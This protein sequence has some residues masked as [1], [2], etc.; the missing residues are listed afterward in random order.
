M[1]NEKQQNNIKILGV[2]MGD[3]ASIGPEITLQAIDKIDST[4]YV[5]LIIGRYDVLKKHY[6]KLLK[7]K[8][9]IFYNDFP[10]LEPKKN[11]LY[12]YDVKSDKKIADLSSGSLET[13]VESKEY[14]DTALNLW[15]DK[16]IDAI[17]TGP[18]NKGLIGKS[19]TPFIGHTEYIAEQIGEENPYM[20]LF[21]PKYRVLLISTHYSIQELP[22]VITEDKILNTVRTGYQAMRRIDREDPLIAV[23]GLD[24]HCGD[25]GA[26]GDFDEKITAKAL[27]IARKEGINV[28]GPLSADTMFIPSKWEKYNLVI[29][30]YHDQGLI[31]FKM[32]AF[33]D[34][35]NVTLGLSIVR[36]SV[37]HG[38]AYDIAGK[39]IAK[40]TSMLEAIK[41]AYSLLT[42]Y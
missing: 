36:T 38:T 19:G 37:D 32:L 41:L 30:Q 15:K 26:V 35:V 42:E 12:I 10:D 31:P 1:Y 13:A 28:E 24:P 39:G 3:P 8:E 6:D 40:E 9:I 33:E 25:H 7:D 20:M 16:K 23:T 14:I 18:V 5:P 27:E 22:Q 4:D 11:R 34:G 29:A 17:V 21:S 2:T